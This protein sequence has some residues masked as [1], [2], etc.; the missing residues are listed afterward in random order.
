MPE[1]E[2][3]PCRVDVAVMRGSTRTTGPFSYS[4]SCDTL[5]PRPWQSAAS[6]TGLGGV[7]FIDFFKPCACVSALV[8]QH[9]SELAPPG[10]QHGFRHAG[11]GQSRGIHIANEDCRRPIDQVAAEFVKVVVSPV[12]DLG[13]NGLDPAVVS[14]ALSDG[15]RRLQSPVELFGRHLDAVTGGQEF[16]QSQ[17][18]ANT[19]NFPVQNRHDRVDRCG[20]SLHLD[21]D[22]EVPASTGIFGKRAD[23]MEFADVLGGQR[24]E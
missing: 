12:F 16:L 3:V 21:G 15:Q 4:K 17:I 24:L 20:T 18:N 23:F 7:G 6:R 10:I 9:G 5:R 1:R 14:G 22:I 2:D 8:L 13:V 11:F 19:G